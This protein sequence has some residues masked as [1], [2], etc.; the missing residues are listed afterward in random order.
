MLDVGRANPM[1]A[2]LFML[3]M[4]PVVPTPC[5]HPPDTDPVT[6]RVTKL[7]S[8]HRTMRGGTTNSAAFAV[9]VERE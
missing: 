3:G 6:A 5:G 4:D 7:S 8:P 1:D 2:D 9:V